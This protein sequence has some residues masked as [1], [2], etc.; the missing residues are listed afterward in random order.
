MKLVSPDVL[1]S[2]LAETKPASEDDPGKTVVD[3]MLSKGL[4]RPDEL[5][6]V[7]ASLLPD[8]YPTQVGGF[9]LL[10]KIGEG[11]MGVVYKA[12]QT[13]MDRTVALKILSP[14]LAR[15]SRYV[16]R[17]QREARA[18]ARLNHPHIVAGIDVGEYQGYHYFAMEFLT[19]RTVQDIVDDK[20]TIAEKRALEICAQIADALSHAWDRGLVHRD[21][22][23]G[24]IMITPD[25]TAK[26]TD[27]GLAKYTQDDEIALTDTGTTLGTAYYLS[28][29]QARGDSTIDTRSD[30]YALGATLY[31]MVT[32]QP[33]YHGT[34]VAVMTQH[35]SG[36]VPD[37]K[38]VKPELSNEICDV[39]R[40]MM[41]KDRRDRYR[42]PEELAI[43]L[44]R[45]MD[46]KKPLLARTDAKIAVLADAAKWE[47]AAVPEM[48]SRDQMRHLK[49]SI[50]WGGKRYHV[51]TSLKVLV[52]VLAALTIVFSTLYIIE[53][54]RK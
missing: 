20:G 4:V 42:T 9:E 46:G 40:M 36:P 34:P 15:S 32:G 12:R 35:V 23:P 3:V 50:G 19:G 16:A 53:L 8:D 24:N 44:R 13:S 38:L 2:C 18:A 33:P 26:I 22:K 27:F 51:P 29:E 11:S 14:R 41:A 45:M 39:I 37:P 30:I 48:V 52:I 54:L 47:D 10:E 5:D 28:P 7:R 6:F 17:F 21:I 31:H 1:Q 43:D 25:G 49:R